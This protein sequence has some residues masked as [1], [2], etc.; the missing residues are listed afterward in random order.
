MNEF[1]YKTVNTYCAFDALQFPKNRISIQL[2]TIAE[3]QC[4]YR[5]SNWINL[6][7]MLQVIT[8]YIPNHTVVYYFLS[9]EGQPGKLL[10]V[11]FTEKLKSKINSA[12]NIRH[13][14]AFTQQ[15]S[16][17][18]LRVLYLQFNQCQNGRVS[19]THAY[20]DR[21]TNESISSTQCPTGAQEVVNIFFSLTILLLFS[22]FFFLAKM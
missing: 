2:P 19:Y 4:K 3:I 1:A 9:I 7:I 16:V 15:Q 11:C 14:L 10:F 12:V 13:T 5:I 21:H 6:A 22:F 18:A 17:N 8:F 20:C